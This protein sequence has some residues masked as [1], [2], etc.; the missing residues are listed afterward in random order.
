MTLVRVDA[1]LKWSVLQGTGGNWVAVCDPLGLTVQG[2]TWAEL[3]EDIGHTLDA[4]LKDLLS[5]RELD[6]FLQDRGWTP[7]APIP[8][9]PE[10]VRFD[11]PFA[12]MMA[13]NT[14]AAV[15][16]SCPSR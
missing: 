3:M 16:H 2:E 11:V 4:L 1:N 13:A 8:E 10:D 7:S 5:T 12:A 9:F 6:R 15:S 14:Y